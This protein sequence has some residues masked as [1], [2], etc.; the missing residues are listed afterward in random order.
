MGM[1]SLT[2]LGEALVSLELNAPNNEFRNAWIL[3]S[4]AIDHMT[5]NPNQFK[6]YLP[7]PRNRRIVVADGTTITMASIGDVQVTSNLVLKNVH[8]PQLSTNI[9]SIQKLTQDLSCRGIF[10]ASFCEFLD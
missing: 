5:H 3:D 8:V 10:Y 9:V 1:C 2:L 4:G 7:Y 6:T